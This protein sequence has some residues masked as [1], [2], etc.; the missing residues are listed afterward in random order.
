MAET[1]NDSQLWHA[2][3]IYLRHAYPA[4]PPAAVKARLDVLRSGCGPLLECTAFEK[5]PITGGV[6]YALR[7]GN[8]F[9]PHM[10]L[11]VECRDHGS[12]CYLRADAHDAHCKPPEASREMEAY[13]TLVRQNRD[14]VAAIETEWGE[15]GLP[16]FKTFLREDIARR[17]TT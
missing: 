8:R 16:T 12:P 11:V 14:M 10:K 4:E 1:I 7:L 9:F 5:K 3:D 6:R 15:L 13:Q 2:I 17:G